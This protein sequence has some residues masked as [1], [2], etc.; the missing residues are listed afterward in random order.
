MATILTAAGCVGASPEVSGDDPELVTGRD[1]YSRSCASCHGSAGQGGRGDRLN[2]GAVLEAYPDPAGQGEL[3]AQGRNSMP[4]F[5]GKLSP[6]EIDAVVRYTREVLNDE[7][8][9]G[10]G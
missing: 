9:A 4:A 1:I 10:G 6:D 2:G 5:T 3:I 7:V 8:P